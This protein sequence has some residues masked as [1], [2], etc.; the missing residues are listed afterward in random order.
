M[1]KR[2][3]SIEGAAFY[4]L[5]RWIDSFS[6]GVKRVLCESR[7]RY[8]GGLYDAHAEHEMSLPGKELTQK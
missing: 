7:D 6:E 2:M 1:N 4:L 8:N 5:A 3:A